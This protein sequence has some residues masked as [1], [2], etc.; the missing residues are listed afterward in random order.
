[1]K[2][3][4]HLFLLGA[5]V[6]AVVPTAVAQTA[7]TGSVVGTVTDPSG[8]LVPGADV[9]LTNLG[10]NAVRTAQ[11]DAKGGY[12]F[13]DVPPGQYALQVLAK[14]FQ[15]VRVT[16]LSVSVN[17]ST[18]AN[19]TLQLGATT[20]TV[21]VTAGAAAE[22]QTTDATVGNTMGSNDLLLL[23]TVHRD[24][25]ELLNFQ[26]A[27]AANG[28]ATRVAGAIDDQ[29]TITLD[30]IDISA[31]IPS[32][33]GNTTAVAVPVDAISEFRVGVSNNGAG[34]DTASGA[35]IT[36]VGRQGTNQFH[37]AAYDYDENNVLNA[38]T[39]ANNHTP[40]RVPNGPLLPS[41]P[42]PDLQ[43]NRFGGRLGGPIQRN[44]TFFFL[45]YEGR[46]FSQAVNTTSLV[47]TDS[48][49]AGILKFAGSNGAVVSY[50]LASASA[51][52]PSGNLAC[53]PR[54]IGISPT[55]KTVDSLYPE[56][57][58]FSE[59]DG[60]NY[61]GFD[62]TATAP[63]VED[64]YT[65]RL[66]H[67]FSPAWRFDGTYSYSRQVE[68]GTGIAS[69]AGQLDI[70]NGKVQELRN[71]P[72]RGDLIIASLTGRLT[73]T[74]LNVFNFGFVRTRTVRQGLNPRQYATLEALPG[75][76]TSAGP[77]ALQT[78]SLYSL[79][80]SNSPFQGEVPRSTQFND[81]LDW[82]KGSH[83]AEVGFNIEHLNEVD[84][85][86]NQLST[87]SSLIAQADADVTSNL[88][89]PAVDRPPTCAG[90]LTTNC[91]PSGSIQQWDRLYASTL[92]L[93]DNI[94]VM[95][96]RNAQ[97]QPQPFGTDLVDNTTLDEFNIYAQDSWHFRPSL[98]AVYGLA[99]A[100]QTT[101]VEVQ[102]R[103]ALLIDAS[104][105][106]PITAESYLSAKL[107]AARMGQ[108]Y[109]PTVAFL[110]IGNSGKAFFTSN[111]GYWAPRVGLAWNPSM[112][113]GWLG[114]LLGHQKTVLRGGFGIVYDRSNGVQ[115]TTLP[116]LGIGFADTPTVALPACNINGAAA[117]PGC[118]TSPSSPNPGLSDFRVGVDGTLP[119]PAFGTT[120]SPIVPTTPYGELATFQLDP[121]NIVGRAYTADFTL[122]RQLPAGLL[123]EIGWVGHYGRNLPQAVDLSNAPYMFADPKSGQTFAQA[124]DAVANALRTGQ[125][126][127][128]E[129]W[130]DD[131]LPNLMSGGLPI[132]GSAY[133]AK[134]FGSSFVNGNVSTLF[135]AM[136]ALRAARGLAAF[137]NRQ[138][139]VIFMRT[140]LGISNYNAMTVTLRK[141]MNKGLS[142]NVNY[143]WSHALDEGLP[144]QNS[145]SF[146]T[147]SYHPTL[148][149]GSSLF[150][151]RQTLSVIAL[152]DLP[153]GR[154]HRF[155]G[156]RWADPIVGGWYVSGIETVQPGFPVGV[157]EGTQ[158]YGDGA[159]LGS[160]TFAIPTVP[161]GSLSPGVH[162]G[163][164]GGTGL[165]LFADPKA[166]IKD[167]RPV[168]LSADGLTGFANPITGLPLVN[169]DLSLGK[170]IN[171]KE[172]AALSV[173]AEFFNFFN[174]VNFVTP[175]L[176]LTS[177]GNFGAITQ[178]LVPTDRI[179]GSRWIELGLRLDF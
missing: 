149:Y 51:C 61:A 26:P 147:N 160:S 23:P 122:Q 167:F 125:T 79:P 57:N 174:N 87:G 37:G 21:V 132:T 131:L 12:T 80:I 55:I 111:P 33:V 14:G 121:N 164:G 100:R 158:V 178:Q 90:A 114:R 63:R 93:V 169:L 76:D 38:N 58:D 113:R 86:D 112:D 74:L 117:G 102:G 67:D 44:K 175:S 145:A 88:S 138:V 91:L 116:Q 144:Y 47:P 53:D 96:V 161:I 1:M 177:P 64:Y 85:R 99:W 27:T 52:G 3:L 115:E 89:I 45:S 34:M 30:G 84:V 162:S 95:G 155:G 48:L 71:T 83:T 137:D 101:P 140:H 97:L 152:W 105:N 11:T 75:T 143:T 124:F 156:S 32:N 104:T 70:I 36:L 159:T 157:A 81:H 171:L 2:V 60:L 65:A 56:P 103:Q 7:N 50:P 129:A 119:I 165:N 68:K 136:D 179:A 46:R 72:I 172:N 176:S 59:G 17:K 18:L 154:G 49:R 77:I 110:P 134:N 146:F 120:T 108:F 22:L 130:F 54:G 78:A 118:N 107:A 141:Q 5:L 94:S 170:K 139:E 4:K 123:L 16:D 6:V 126:T 82:I 153:L 127:P 151:L 28:P 39:W 168:Q 135:N 62:A 35:Q 106:Q 31:Q 15:A 166:A 29:N 20:Q 150:D 163:V 25:A 8:A 10:T 133:M 128:D 73:P 43:D 69:P 173:S 148:E 92:G 142:F 24:A 42:R 9:T 13:P 66:D 41:T 40:Y 109:N 19:I 98:T